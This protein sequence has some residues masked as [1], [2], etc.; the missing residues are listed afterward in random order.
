MKWLKIK[1]CKYIIALC[2][3]GEDTAMVGEDISFFRDGR[4]RAEAKLRVLTGG[5]V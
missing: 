5:D 3:Y 2:N 4:D 1:L